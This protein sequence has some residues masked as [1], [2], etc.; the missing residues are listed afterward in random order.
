LSAWTDAAYVALQQTIKRTVPEGERREAALK[1]VAH[2]D[3]QRKD[4]TLASCDPSI[5]PPPTVQEWR[6]EMERAS[7]DEDTY[8]KALA[9]ILDQL[10]CSGKPDSIHVLRGLVRSKRIKD[11]GRE[12]PAMI[13]RFMSVACPVS[14][15]LTDDDKESLRTIA[16]KNARKSKDNPA[17]QGNAA[18]K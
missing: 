1:R 15:A 4:D 5:K 10:V 7:V 12:A 18:P 2:L 17:P 3:C 16:K 11:V 6:K 8:R 13:A 9:T 14:A